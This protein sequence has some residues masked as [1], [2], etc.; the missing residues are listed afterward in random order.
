MQVS[1]FSIRLNST[2]LEHDQ[3]QLNTFLNSVSFKKSSTQF[4]D[5]E[6]AYWSVIVHYESEEQEKP[7][8]LERKSYDDLNSKDKQVYG[9]LNQWRNEKSEA[10]KLKKYLICHNSELID[11]AMYKPSSLE[12]LQQ[13]KGFGKQK[14][15][16]FG[17]DILA[18]LNAV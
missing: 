18:I 11:L 4:V 17:E 15:E 9:Y 7:K 5:G 3:H 14:V 16:K 1:I 6:E 10:L 8:R 2:F 12:E 13:I